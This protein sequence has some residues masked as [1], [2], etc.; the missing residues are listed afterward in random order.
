MSIFFG[1][2]CD[3]RGDGCERNYLADDVV[4]NNA[5]MR[6]QVILLMENAI[7][8]GWK[9]KDDTACC[10]KCFFLDRPE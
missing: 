1:L 2:L 7:K 6:E 3:H 5:D 4:G 8:A 9:L 10:P